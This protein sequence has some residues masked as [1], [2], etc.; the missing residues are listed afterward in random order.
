M[1]LLYVKPTGT[2]QLARNASELHYFTRIICV[3]FHRGLGGK[4]YVRWVLPSAC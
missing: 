2:V 3:Y 1:Q 4:K